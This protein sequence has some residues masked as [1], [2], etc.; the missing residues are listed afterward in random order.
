MLVNAYHCGILEYYAK[1][2][3]TGVSL[4]DIVRQLTSWTLSICQIESAY[5]PERKE[6]LRPK[7]VNVS[8]IVEMFYTESVSGVMKFIL[9]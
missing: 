1:V 8:M 4:I 6:N 7:N 2:L 3:Y 5:T 9:I